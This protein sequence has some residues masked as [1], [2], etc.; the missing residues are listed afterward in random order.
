[1]LKQSCGPRNTTTMEAWSLMAS[2]GLSIYMLLPPGYQ[3]VLVRAPVREGYS[4]PGLAEAAVSLGPYD[5]KDSSICQAATRS[6]VFLSWNKILTLQRWRAHANWVASQPGWNLNAPA[7]PLAQFIPSN[8]CDRHWGPSDRGGKYSVL[9]E[10]Q[11][12]AM[13]CYYQ[14][15]YRSIL[16]L[17]WPR[18]TWSEVQQIYLAV[19]NALAGLSG[20]GKNEIRRSKTKHSM[21]LSKLGLE[22]K[23]IYTP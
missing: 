8:S 23:G 18:L 12:H 2:L 21:E 3:E 10:G 17:M 22:Y 1:M 13:H 19:I 7:F 6:K 15:D 16:L 14:T 5:P 9:T 11:F 20:L 4:R